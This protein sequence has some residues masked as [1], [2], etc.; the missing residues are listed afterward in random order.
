MKIHILTLAI[1]AAVAAEAA[2]PNIVFIYADDIGYGDFSSYGATKISTPNVDK[3]AA[4]GVR[5]TNGHSTAATCTPSRYALF[6]GRYA[7]RQKGTQILPGDAN[8]IIPTDQITL[9]SLLKKAGYAT[10]L[11]G[12]WHLGLG[13]SEIDWNQ[14]VKPGPLE[15]G[16]D[17]AL[18][19][20]ATGDRTPTVLMENRRVRGLD[21]ADPL[22][23]SYKENFPGEPTGILNPELLKMVHSHGHNMS[24]HNGIGRIGFQTGGVS[25]RWTDEDIAGEL[26]ARA[27]KFIE[28]DHGKPFFLYLSTHDIHVPRAP[29]Q[30]FV[31]KS[32]MGPRGD[33]LLEFDWTVGEITAA[34][35]RKGLTKDTLL[36]ISSDNGPRPR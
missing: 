19:I 28:K 16:F 23:V 1:A 36:I 12:K 9:P 8:L 24:V 13:S 32:G 25:A 7:W 29:H 6:T 2:T 5:H 18:F 21:A 33:A 11:V 17:E 34:L 3:V 31:G 27:V 35:D 30:R 20:P 15:I 10:S 14:D 26:A 4:G 22:R